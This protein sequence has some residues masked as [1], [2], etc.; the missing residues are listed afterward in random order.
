[1]VGKIVTSAKDREDGPMNLFARNTA[2]GLF[3]L[4][5]FAMPA[6]SARAQGTFNEREVR[7][8]TSED[9]KTDVWVMDFKFKDPRMI[10]VYAPGQGARIYWYLWYQVINRSKEPH[11]FVPYFEIVTL[12]YPGVYPDSNFPTVEE[13]IRKVEDPTKYQD[14]KNSVTIS[15]DPIPPS[16]PEAFPRAITGVAI[17]E[18]SSTANPKKRDP[19]VKELSDTTRFSVFVR[20]LS[21]GYVIVDP[22]VAGQSSV[23]R[24]KTLQL[25]FRRQGDRYSI[26]SRDVSFVAPAEWIYR[27]GSRTLLETK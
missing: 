16:R 7:S 4:A 10:K 26:D 6:P 14:I 18:A 24:Y 1:M 27:P 5:A 8:E 15:A 11:R 17:W 25:N 13:A 12:D 21:N 23:T 3:F 22:L 2:V 9:D 20:G 19:T